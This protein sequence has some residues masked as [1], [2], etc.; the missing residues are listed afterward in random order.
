L[1]IRVFI[2]EL[3][4]IPFDPEIPARNYCLSRVATVQMCTSQFFTTYGH[5][6]YLFWVRNNTDAERTY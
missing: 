4:N 2:S 1:T 6:S 5:G 3:R